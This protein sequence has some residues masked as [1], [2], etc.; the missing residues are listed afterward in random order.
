MSIIRYFKYKG[1]KEGA[2]FI[3]ESICALCASFTFFAV[4]KESLLL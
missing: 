3:N 1:R 2:K 4:K